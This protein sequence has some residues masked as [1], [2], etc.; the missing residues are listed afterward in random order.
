MEHVESL[1]ALSEKYE[2]RSAAKLLA[3]ARRFHVP[4]TLK[5]AKAAVA[6]DV[7]RQLFAPKPRSLGQSAA[8][9]PGKRL[10]ADLIDLSN[11]AKAARGEHRYGLLVSDVFTRKAWA[12][13][14]RYKDAATVNPAF[15]KI[16]KEV[17]GHGTD[18][19][20]TTDQGNEFRGLESQHVLPNGAIH[21]TKDVHDRNAIAVVDRTMQTLKKDLAAGVARN[22]KP[23]AS[24]LRTVAENYNERPNAAVHG[25]PATADEEGPQRFF[26]EQDNAG[27]FM[28]NRALTMR[29]TEALRSAGAFRAPVYG[30]SRSFRPGYEN[31]PQVLGKITH[32]AGYVQNTNGRQTLLKDALPVPKGSGKPLGQLTA[33]RKQPAPRA[34]KKAAVAPPE[35]QRVFEGG[36]SGSGANPLSAAPVAASHFTEAQKRRGDAVSAH[37]MSYVHKTT[38]EGRAQAAKKKADAEAE[39]ERKRQAKLAVS[40]EKELAKQKKQFA[41]DVKRLK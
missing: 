19:V 21:R 12:E 9:A 5:D 4:A 24:Q 13:P 8:E 16:L 39:K 3:V 17:P 20:V 23:W 30:E 37:I 14:L 1:R 38:P 6:P 22:G 41:R 40:V 26:I 18:A 31:A 7:G 2:A 33:P 28:H 32:G 35:P 29:R 25:A 11:N 15:R 34:A 10:Q 36:S 27:K